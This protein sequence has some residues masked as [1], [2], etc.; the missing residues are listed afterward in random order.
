MVSRAAATRRRRG[1]LAELDERAIEQR[2]ALGQE[3]G[4]AAVRQHRQHAGGVLVPLLV[5]IGAV[6]L[7]GKRQPDDALATLIQVGRRDLERVAGLV[8]ASAGR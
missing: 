3:G 7:L 6:P 4:W 5:K 2:I 8:G 1:L